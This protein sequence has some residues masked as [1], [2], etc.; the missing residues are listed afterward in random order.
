VQAWL[1]TVALLVFLMVMVGGATRL[2]DSGLSIT[3]WQPIL[4]AIPPM[5]D[6]DWQD[7]FAKYKQIPEYRDVNK[8]MSLDAFK[9]IFWW[10]WAH[11]FLGRIIGIAFAVP[12]LLFWATGRLPQGLG[13]P[14]LGLLGLGGLQGAIGWYMVQSGLADG[15]VDVSPYRLTLHLSLAILILGL[16]VWTALGIAPNRTRAVL[17]DTIS[18]IQRR[19]AVLLVGLLYLQIIAGGFVAGHKAGLVYNTWPLMENS[20]IPDGLALLT[21]WYLNFVENITTIQFNHR[22][23]AYAIVAIG[24]VHAWSVWRAAD[25][26]RQAVS[27]VVLAGGLVG[28]AGLGVVTLLAVVDAKIPVVWGIAHQAGAAALFA[29]AVWHLHTMLRRD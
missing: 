5:T 17:L 13:L 19:R 15:M 25:D 26:E 10:E 20:L 8:G 1:A 27:A 6:A 4:G 9:V 29:V 24:L 3:E 12:L 28:Q 7:A 2:T 23:L 16:L 22:M 21:P 14:L 11:R 18:P